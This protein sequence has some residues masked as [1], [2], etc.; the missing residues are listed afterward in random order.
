MKTTLLTLFVT[1]LSVQSF[2][3]SD[4]FELVSSQR[5][6]PSSADFCTETAKIDLKGSTMT[7]SLNPELGTDLN[8][9][10]KEGDVVINKINQGAVTE[11]RKSFAHGETINTKI[12]ATLENGVLN[13][14]SVTK[15]SY[16]FIPNGKASATLVINF[17]KTGFDIEIQ[18]AY[19][20][21]GSSSDWENTQ[22][23]SYKLVK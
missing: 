18:R 21:L 9:D 8:I 11:K 10:S 20:S 15:F 23:C 22:T 17:S 16:G 3:S 12:E 5:S 6:N 19:D 4:N 14:E 2:A 1:L 7:I 13:V